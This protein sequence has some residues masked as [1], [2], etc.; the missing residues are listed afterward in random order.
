MTAHL[1]RIAPCGRRVVGPSS[2][3]EGLG[4][5]PPIGGSETAFLSTF[6]S[7]AALVCLYP[8]R[9]YLYLTDGR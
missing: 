4:T 7:Q 1:S 9:Y 2:P 3:F 6:L 8:L 5:G